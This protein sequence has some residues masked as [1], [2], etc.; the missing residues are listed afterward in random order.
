LPIKLA[1]ILLGGFR[2]GELKSL[3]K[4]DIKGNSGLFKMCEL[5]LRER[6]ASTTA[7]KRY[8]LGKKAG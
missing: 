6:L 2:E 1:A 5:C 7:L 8:I 4:K 3:G